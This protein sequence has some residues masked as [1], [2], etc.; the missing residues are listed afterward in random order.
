MIFMI[1]SFCFV[2]SASE[3]TLAVDNAIKKNESSWG[4]AV[5]KKIAE[6]KEAAK[7]KLEEDKKA[8]AD[9]KK[10]ELLAEEKKQFIDN[11]K[12][13]SI[14]KKKIMQE[15]NSM[16]YPI[17]GKNYLMLSTEVT[18][19]LYKEVTGENPSKFKGENNPVEE[20]SWREAIYFCNELS[21]K[22]GLEPCY[23][24]E[25]Y[26]YFVDYKRATEKEYNKA[27][28]QKRDRNF[29]VEFDEKANGFRLPTK[30][31]WEYAARGGQNYEYSGSDNLDEVGWYIR[32]CGDKYQTNP[33]AQKK[34]NGFGLYDMSGNVKEL[35]VDSDKG[36]VGSLGSQFY[37]CGGSYDDS[38]SYCKVSSIS[39]RGDYSSFDYRGFRIVC[40]AE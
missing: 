40:K 8:I 18:Q 37:E 24:N 31:E 26:E 10:A 11:A 28:P 23:K 30:E 20:M 4:Q 15:T 27:K 2:S 39:K 25:G 5:K 36:K 9:K 3:F 21:K 1:I 17:P 6:D 16:M 22:C 32:N 34:A 33:V 14:N 38:A 29:F 35:C 13:Y 7:K 12:N 19:K